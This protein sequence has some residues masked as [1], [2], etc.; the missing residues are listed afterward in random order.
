M[1]IKMKSK[2]PRNSVFSIENRFSRSYAETFLNGKQGTHRI[3]ASVKQ[4]ILS[5]LQHQYRPAEGRLRRWPP[6][7]EE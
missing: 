3:T 5:G 1:Y 7:L 4:A 2:K 6:F